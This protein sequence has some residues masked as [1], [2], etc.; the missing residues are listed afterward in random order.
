MQGQAFKRLEP[1]AEL[2]GGGEVGEMTFELCVIVL[3][4]A[5]DGRSLDGAVP[6]FDMA[7][8]PWM[9]RLCQAMLDV[10]IGAGRLE[11]MAAEGHA[12]GPH[13]LDVFWHPAIPCGLGEVGTVVRQDDMD[14]IEN[15]LGD[16]T[17]EAAC[18]A[19]GCLPVQRDEGELGRPVDDDQQLKS[20]FD[21]LHL[22]DVDLKKADRVGLEHLLRG[23]FA[24]NVGQAP[25]SVAVQAAMQ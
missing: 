15:C 7:V 22:G 8:S 1:P 18:H 13:R 12:L 24:V 5:P 19:P 2:V 20:A 17:R 21:R 4:V 25:D 10:E 6:A 11:G 23:L 14:L 9:R 16:V 3:G